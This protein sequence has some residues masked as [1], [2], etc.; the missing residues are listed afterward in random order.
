MNDTLRIVLMLLAV[1]NLLGA[2]LCSNKSFN[3]LR[4]ILVGLPFATLALLFAIAIEYYR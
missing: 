1:G 4:D 2:S 3:P